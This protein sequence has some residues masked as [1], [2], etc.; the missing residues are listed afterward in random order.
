[1][2]QERSIHAAI[3]DAKAADFTVPSTTDQQTETADQ[4]PESSTD[5]FSDNTEQDDLGDNVELF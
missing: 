5:I 4:G 2:Q 1:M 3:L